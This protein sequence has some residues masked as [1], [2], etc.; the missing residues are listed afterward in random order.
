MSPDSQDD[1]DESARID[2]F[3]ELI[4]SL[5]RWVMVLGVSV[6]LLLLARGI[7]RGG[8]A[9]YC[10][11]WFLSLFT[12]DHMAHRARHLEMNPLSPGDAKIYA[13][14]TFFFRWLVLIVVIVL[15]SRVGAEPV[16]A[17]AALLLLQ[18]AILCRSMM[19]LFAELRSS[20]DS[21]STGGEESA[22]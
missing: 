20:R 2:P 8:L 4:R 13:I 11:G 17:V 9:G 10:V 6:L 15:A 21:G 16:A 5:R 1:L 7:S 18:A 3:P 12:L 19:V 14:R 22:G